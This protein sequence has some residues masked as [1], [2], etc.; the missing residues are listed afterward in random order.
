MRFIDVHGKTPV[1]TPVNPSFPHWQPWSDIRWQAWLK[2]SNDYK[3]AL[4]LL[5]Q[6]GDLVARNNFID[7]HSAHWGELKPWLQVLS[8]GKCWFSES[9]ELFSHYD[10]EHFRP[11]K[12]TK[13]LDGSVKDG[14]W[15]LAFDYTNFRLCAN[16]G[17]RKKGI[18]FP[19]HE[20][21]CVSTYD[22][23]R[24]ESE[25]AYLLDPTDAG[26]VSLI[27]FDEEGKAIPQPSI[28]EWQK[29]RVL[30][31]IKLLKLNEHE[32]LAEERRKVWQKVTQ[33]IADINATK[34]K[35]CQPGNPAAK[36]KYRNHCVTIKAF[37]SQEAELSTVAKY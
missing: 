27:A 32:S 2:K 16:V 15:W 18:Y 13:A 6:Q 34:D 36:E 5:H 23:P 30:E 11:K 31:T 25:E 3:K 28:T 4:C 22:N 21:S 20:N 7:N 19:L 24:E 1:N 26:D 9:K 33:V 29:Q 12:E 10:V 35:L 17:N 14:Y 37:T 8:L